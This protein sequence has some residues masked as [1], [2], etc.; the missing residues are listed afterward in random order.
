V[1]ERSGPQGERVKAFIY[2]DDPAGP[3]KGRA[4]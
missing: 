4:E 1:V 3:G 2:T